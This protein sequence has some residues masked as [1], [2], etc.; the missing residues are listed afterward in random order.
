MK[1]NKSFS[2]GALICLLVM[3]A[4]GGLLAWFEAAEDREYILTYFDK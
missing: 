2:S 1:K 4:V 3:I